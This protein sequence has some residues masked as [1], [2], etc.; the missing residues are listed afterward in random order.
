M[1]RK[2]CLLTSKLV[3]NAIIWE[4]WKVKTEYLSLIGDSLS[5]MSRIRNIHFIYI[6]QW[7]FVNIMALKAQIA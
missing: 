5:L 7:Y 3:V 6:R 4:L 1:L 2:Y